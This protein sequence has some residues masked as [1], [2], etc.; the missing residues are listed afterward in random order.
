MILQTVQVLGL[1][2]VYRA[3]EDT[4]KAVLMPVRGVL[5]RGIDLHRIL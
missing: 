3:A 5:T 1:V 2:C 4:V